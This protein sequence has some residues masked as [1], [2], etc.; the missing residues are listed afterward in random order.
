MYTNINDIKKRWI[1]TTPICEDKQIEIYIQ[2]AEQLIFLEYPQAQ[3]QIVQPAYLQRFITAVS[4]MVIRVLQNPDKIRQMQE[5]AGSFS[6]GI[7][8][9]TETL[10]GM[11]I[12]KKER[13]LL[14][15]NNKKNNSL[16]TLAPAGFKDL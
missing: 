1:A 13:V 4:Q 10:K 3:E 11:E 9:G 16:I 8:Y 2:D 12:T 6:G 14:E 5:S 15:N 7:T